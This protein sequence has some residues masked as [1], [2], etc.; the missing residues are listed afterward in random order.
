MKYVKMLGLAALAAMAVMALVGAGTASATTLDCAGVHCNVGTVI[1]AS[2]SGSAKLTTT[3]GTV[4]DTCTGGTVKGVTTTTGSATETVQGNIEE[5][6]W[7]P[8]TEPTTTIAKGTLEIHWTSGLNGT[9]TA[10]SVPSEVTVQ[11]TIFGS[12]IFTIAAGGDIGTVTGTTSGDA[13]FHINAVAS[14]KSG[15]CP[16][17]TKWEGT[18]IV[19]SPTPLAVTAG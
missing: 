1:D 13:V 12:C 8:C 11:T 15:F 17:T 18:Y 3:E 10:G 2:L 14:R 16:S 5:L 7:G 9:L 6:T 19:T 4:L